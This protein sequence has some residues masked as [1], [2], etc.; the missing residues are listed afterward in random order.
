MGQLREAHVGGLGWTWEGKSGVQI[1]QEFSGADR[2]QE[3]IKRDSLVTHPCPSSKVPAC[4]R[5][6]CTTTT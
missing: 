6:S 4:L 3:S 5:K 2:L 1:G